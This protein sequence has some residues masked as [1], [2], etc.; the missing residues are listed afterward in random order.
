M[1]CEIIGLI[2]LAIVLCS[3]PVLLLWCMDYIWNKE[4]IEPRERREKERKEL[5][6]KNKGKSNG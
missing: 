3:T 1:T 5:E 6:N 4:I 2:V